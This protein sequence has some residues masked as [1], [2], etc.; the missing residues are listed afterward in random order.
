MNYLFDLQYFGCI[1]LYKLSC[2]KSNI[3][4]ES[5]ETFQKMSFRNRCVIAGANGLLHLSIPL[6]NGREQATPIREVRICYNDKWQMKHWRAIT[7]AYGRSPFFEYYEKE[8][9]AF[10]DKQY[11]FLFDW[12]WDLISWVIN[13][14][15]LNLQLVLTD[16]YQK[17]YSSESGILDFRNHWLPKNFQQKNPEIARYKQVFEDRI[18]FQNNLCI[19]DLLFCEGPNAINYLNE[20]TI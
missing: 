17:N 13:K 8:L 2:K 19:I 15:S 10:Y 9:E 3:I 18:G 4:F 16:H 20:T 14:L 7:S 11:E 6:I 5:C 1:D 12:N